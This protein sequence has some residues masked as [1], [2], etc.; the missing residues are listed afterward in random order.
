MGRQVAGATLSARAPVEEGRFARVAL[1][2]SLITSG[3]FAEC[4][5]EQQREADAGRDVPS[6]PQLLIEK[7][8]IRRAQAD[9]IYR[10]MTTRS[11]EQWRNQF[12]QIALRKGLITEAQ[13]RE[14]LEEQTRLVMSTGSA[15]ILGH[16]LLE[17]GHMTERQVRAILKAQA[18]RHLGILYELEAATRPASVRLAGLLRRHRRPLLAVAFAAGI[19]AAGALGALCHGWATA[20]PLLDLLCDQCGHHQRVPARAIAKPC[21]HCG[22]GRLFTPLH[23]RKCDVWFAL[24]VHTAPGA[25]PWLQPCPHC[26]TLDHVDVPHSLEGIR[27]S[28]RPARP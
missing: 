17:R 5:D 2:G 21:A 16:L 11:P 25:E 18:Q 12:G 15:P 27:G 3:Q 8:Y 4:V 1:W 28:P 20:P 10:V 7:G 23:C 24:R 19:L 6:I 13:L 22:T 9:A 26:R 14:G